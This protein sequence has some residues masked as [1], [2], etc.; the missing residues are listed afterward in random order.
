MIKI[1]KS[2][3]CCIGLCLVSTVVSANSFYANN[4][5]Q[6]QAPTAFALQPESQ[7]FLAPAYDMTIH[8]ADEL[9]LKIADDKALSDAIKRWFTLSF[10]QQI[11]WLRKVFTLEIETF[12][13]QLPS[14]IAPKLLI[15]NHS[16]PNKMVYFDF[17]ITQPDS[18]IVYLNPQKL[19]TEDRYAA[20]ALL[21]HETRHSFQFQ[22]AA[23]QDS[24]LAN[25]YW[26]AFSAQKQLKGLG[27]SD[28][29]TLLNEYE[30]FQFGNYVVGKLTDWQIDM[31]A[32]GTFASQYDQ[33]GVLKIDLISLGNN[34]SALSLLEQYNQLAKTQYQLRQQSTQ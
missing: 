4:E 5:F 27:F 17:D 11:P 28:F 1:I 26:A 3:T 24:Q 33:Q 32:M 12:K 31:I 30:A 15:D 6:Q 19:A 29:L 13:Q 7:N 9:L 34:G 2:L 23:K 10:E 20:L 8:H 18:G 14:F 16:Y 22:L 21:V 25:G